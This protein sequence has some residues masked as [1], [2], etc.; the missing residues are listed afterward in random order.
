MNGHEEKTATPRHE[1]QEE[2]I[3]D[4]TASDAKGVRAGRIDAF[5]H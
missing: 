4:E 2:R 3:V 1:I 5:S